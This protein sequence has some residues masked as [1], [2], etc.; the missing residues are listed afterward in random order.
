V[1]WRWPTL[2][3]ALGLSL[4]ACGGEERAAVKAVRA[5]DEAVIR[6]Y[7]G[8]DASAVQ[9]LATAEELNRLAVLVDL[10]RASHLTLM[11]ELQRFEARQVELGREAATVTTE[12]RWRYFDRPDDP[13]Q[14]NGETFLADMV[15][16][17][18][19]VK[20]GGAWKVRKARTFSG[21]YLEPKGYQPG[22]MR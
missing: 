17:Y 7:R 15:L 6:A 19:L 20:D 21:H 10:K 5:Y 9:G 12:E 8:N 11:S 14:P 4:T 22:S 18:S 1:T 2:L 13:K 3:L 16:E